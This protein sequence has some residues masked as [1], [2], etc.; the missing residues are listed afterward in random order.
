MT[1]ELFPKVVKVDSQQLKL[2]DD[3]DDGVLKPCISENTQ[4]C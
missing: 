2:E 3:S 1:R 4:L